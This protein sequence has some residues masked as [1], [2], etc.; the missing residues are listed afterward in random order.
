MKEKELQTISIQ[1]LQ[2]LLNIQ[3]PKRELFSF[4]CTAGTWKFPDQP[5]RTDSMMLLIVSS[6]R[7]DYSIN[8]QQHSITSG[9]L[10]CK[11]PDGIIKVD[12]ISDDFSGYGICISTAFMQNMMLNIQS[13]SP[14]MAHFRS[15]SFLEIPPFEENKLKQLLLLINDITETPSH[16]NTQIVQSLA[17][18]LVYMLCDIFK[19][20]GIPDEVCEDKAGGRKE[21]Y[22]KKFLLLLGKHYKNQRSVKFYADQLFITPK[23]LSSI[24]KHTGKSVI[25]W[26]DDYVIM[27]AKSL[28]KYSDLSVQEIS[29]QL[30][31]ANPSFFG[32]YFKQRTGVSPGYFKGKYGRVA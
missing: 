17:S 13:I 10:L 9:S 23:Y 27:E 5:F 15:V 24:M 21:Y 31:F 7:L 4:L 19:M 20:T 30:N 26:V 22:I 2:C 12:H 14:L 6:G 32:R 25:D 8:L 16:Y 29:Y 3:G 1:E 18:S 11:R 28:L